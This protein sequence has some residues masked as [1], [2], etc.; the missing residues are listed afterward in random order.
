[1]AVG[2]L[3]GMGVEVER[4][5]NSTRGDRAGPVLPQF[6][7]EVVTGW[8]FGAMDDGAECAGRAPERYRWRAVE[9]NGCARRVAGRLPTRRGHLPV[10]PGRPEHGGILPEEN[11]I[12]SLSAA[13]V[14]P[15]AGAESPRVR[16]TAVP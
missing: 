2:M 7:R 4:P 6:S 12:E 10:R 9:G 14:D 16:V 8:S 13:R 1:M 11:R 5:G 15:L 3:R